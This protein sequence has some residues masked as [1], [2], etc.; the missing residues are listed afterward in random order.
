MEPIG[1]GPE[2]TTLAFEPCNENHAIVEAVF[3]VV[4]LQGFT[5]DDRSSVKAA[6]SKWQGLLP[7]L[8]EEGVLNI[9][10][11]APDAALP[12]PPIAPLA[13]ARFRAD[14]EVEWRLLLT[15]DALVV[16]CRSYTRWKEV[17]TVVR[18]LFAEIAGAIQSREQKIRSVALEYVDL[19]RSVD[20]DHYDARH[21]LRESNSVP[22]GV[23]GRGPSW[24]LHQGWFV[25]T[26]A[27]VP[28]R[29]LQ[30]MHI[31]STVVD[32]RPQ[33]RFHTSQRFEMRDAPDLQSMFAE[34]DTLVDGLFDFLHGSSK[35]LLAN[36]L[37]AEMAQR[38]K[39]H[40]D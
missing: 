14:G 1:C 28:G 25:D 33:V 10:V 4:G 23:F 2:A 7:S 11:A 40:A 12:P 9:A 13:F 3:A 18:D 34:P 26:Q 29:T 5:P 31:D 15:P 37:T 16:N 6:H 32:D 35:A 38:I 36:F 21:L 27:P 22:P 19:F 24:H 8:Q 39:L 17:W 30:R 20:G